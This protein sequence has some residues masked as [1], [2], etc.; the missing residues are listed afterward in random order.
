[1]VSDLTGILETAQNISTALSVVLILIALIA[2]LISGIGIMN[3]MLV[4]V[5]QRTHEI[6]VRKA[7]GAPRNAILCQFLMEA[8]LI[9]GMGALIGI[10]IAV[11]IPALINFLIGFFPVA[12]N[13][14]IPTSWLSGGPG[15]SC[16]LL[17]GRFVRI[18]ACAPG[19]QAESRGIATL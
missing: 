11:S 7:I 16:I 2:L 3:I 17:N 9:S 1:M 13:I 12:E 5:T 6:G 14:V 8:V 15:V 4:T 10:V 18:F 19:F